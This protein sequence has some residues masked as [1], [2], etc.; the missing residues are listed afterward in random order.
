MAFTLS[1]P[2]Q[3]I[4]EIKKSRFLV[5]VA[6]IS[7][8][9][10]ASEFI[11][12]VSDPTATHNCWAWKIAQ[13]YRFNDDGE[14]SGTAGRPIL[15]AIEG[16][17]CDSIVAI[18]TRW[19]GGIKLGT[20]G[21]ARAYG[22]SVA[23][24]LQ[25]APLIELIPRI[26]C[27]FSCYYHEWPLLENRLNSLEATIEQQNFDAEGISLLLALPKQNISTLQQ[28]LNDL[29]KGRVQANILHNNN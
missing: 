16:Q 1:E 5:Q 3:V 26:S 9:E 18:V 12:K 24:C 20:G 14:P 4:E 28:L 23:R 29:T 6:P 7:T 25:Q 27:Q 17:Q 2:F 22:G 13:N 10:Q 11:E 19:F 8:I 21:L 15:T